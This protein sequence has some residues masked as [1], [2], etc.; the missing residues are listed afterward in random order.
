ME[1]D[2]NLNLRYN[3]NLM[4]NSPRWTNNT[5]TLYSFHPM[6]VVEVVV[7]VVVVVT[8]KP[9]RNGIGTL[10]LAVNQ[11]HFCDKHNMVGPGFSI[12]YCLSTFQHSFI[13]GKVHI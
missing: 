1:S 10:H 11:E 8:R 5:D 9:R 2:P 13:A 3:L 7:L 4:G 12:N 6:V